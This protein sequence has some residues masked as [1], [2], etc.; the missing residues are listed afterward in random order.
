[1]SKIQVFTPPYTQSTN[2]KEV[3][4]KRI[5]YIDTL[6]VI[7]CFLVMLTH[8]TRP[9]EDVSLGIWLGILSFIGSPSS[10]LFLSLSGTVLLPVR[11][12]MK[13][14]YHRRFMKLIP[15]VIFWSIIILLLHYFDGQIT[16]TQLTESII[17]LPLKPAIGVYWFVY[18]IAGLYLLAP[19]VSSWLRDCSKKQLEF[20]LLLWFVNMLIPYLNL[21]NLNVTFTNDSHY[22]V[23]NYFSGFLGY[24]LLGYYLRLYPIKIGVNKKWIALCIGV[25]AYVVT[26]ATLKFK[27]LDVAPYMDNLQIGSAFLVA[28]LYTVIQSNPIKVEFIRNLVSELA[29]YSFGIYLVHIVVVRDI[30]WKIFQSSTMHPLPETFLIA[31]ISMVACYS[32]IKLISYLPFSKITIGV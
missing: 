11:R 10:E 16:A 13:E 15:P 29:K 2:S 28:M 8:S 17:L 32:I 26:I 24:W 1:M 22:W 30:V 23:L 21:L 5:E 14:F 3:K 12:P 9:V 7:A 27:G 19:F 20:V 6:R 4:K 25:I 31:T 18:A